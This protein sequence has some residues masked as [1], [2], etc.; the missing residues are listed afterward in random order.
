MTGDLG[1]PGHCSLSCG[2]C[3]PCAKDD[4]E[5]YNENRRKAGYLVYTDLDSD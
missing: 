1:S 4:R 5:C 3:T 2:S